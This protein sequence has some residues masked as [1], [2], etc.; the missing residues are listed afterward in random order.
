MCSSSICW[1]CRCAAPR[2]GA[3]L[4]SGARTNPGCQPRHRRAAASPRSDSRTTT[5]PR[6]IAQRLWR[7]LVEY[8]DQMGEA[9][10][11]SSVNLDQIARVDAGGEPVLR[12]RQRRV[13]RPG[14]AR[15]GR[16]W[17]TKAHDCSCALQAARCALLRRAAGHARADR[18]GQRAAVAAIC[19][20]RGLADEDAGAPERR[21][22]LDRASGRER[23]DEFGAVT[24]RRMPFAPRCSGATRPS[25]PSRR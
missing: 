10:L 3:V 12:R 8:R 19:Q 9:V 23:R 5:R 18:G 6:A 25:R 1:R 2:R 17:R 14:G 11:L 15:T 21:R 22:H 13:P 7:R 16:S 4:S 20:R 24:R